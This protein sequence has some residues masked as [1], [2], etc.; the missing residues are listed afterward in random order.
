MK[1]VRAIN[2][3]FESSTQA[4]AKLEEFQL[5]SN[6]TQYR[7]QKHPKAGSGQKKLAFLTY[8]TPILNFSK[9][10]AC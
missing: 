6:I 7:D 1:K 4:M 3:Y 5:T 8:L 2:G 9:L 10:D